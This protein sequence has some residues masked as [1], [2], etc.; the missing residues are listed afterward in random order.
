MMIVNIG[1]NV[2][3]RFVSTLQC[4]LLLL[5]FVIFI[6]YVLTGKFKR[7]TF[8]STWTKLVVS[9]RVIVKYLMFSVIVHDVNVLFACI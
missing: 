4:L 9:V 7:R 8:H 5:L 2:Q 1:V 3:L 6:I